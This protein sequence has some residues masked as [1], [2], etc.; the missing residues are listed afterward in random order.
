MNKLRLPKIFL[1]T[2]G[3]S[4]IQ[5]MIGV[6]VGM[7]AL[8]GFSQGFLGMQ[9]QFTLL[10]HKFDL[11]D[12]VNGIRSIINAGESCRNNLSG[13]TL[14]TTSPTALA[15][16]R[17]TLNQIRA[18]ADPAGPIYIS[19][20]DPI[21]PHS[22]MVTIGEISV[23]NFRLINPDSV[24]FDLVV[25]PAGDHR[26]KPGVI[27]GMVGFL[28]ATNP[29]NA[30]TIQGCGANSASSLTCREVSGSGTGSGIE[31]YCNPGEKLLNGG[32]WCVAGNVGDTTI[33]DSFSSPYGATA[34]DTGYMINSAPITDASG[35][36]GWEVDCLL[37]DPTMPGTDTTRASAIITCCL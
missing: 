26:I 3:V 19:V 32:G 6:G 10:K 13:F 21:S 20:G 29:A 25:T 36:E 11:Q 2:R 12:K 14:D 8:V 28:D 22:T 23:E 15:S 33:R 30:K 37:R 17:H 31:L 35:N 7:I 1:S 5:V 18:G 16:A 9:N 27:S 4:L 24:T 34:A